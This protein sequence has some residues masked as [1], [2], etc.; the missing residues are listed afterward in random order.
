MIA[1][2][3]LLNATLVELYKTVSASR[4]SLPQV[5]EGV[6]LISR[7]IDPSPGLEA[8]ELYLKYEV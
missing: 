1:R 2:K 8:C 3:T 7:R 6:S 4:D 5:E